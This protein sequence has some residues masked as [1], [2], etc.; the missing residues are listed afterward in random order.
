MPFLLFS[1][2]C[3]FTFQVMMALNKSVFK[4]DSGDG[5][6]GWIPAGALSIGLIS[7]AAQEILAT[8]YNYIADLMTFKENWKTEA[9]HTTALGLKLVSFQMLNYYVVLLFTAFYGE[10]GGPCV[11]DSEPNLLRIQ[12]Q[13][14]ERTGFT[15]PEPGCLGLLDDERGAIE[16]ERL[17]FKAFLAETAFQ[18]TPEQARNSVYKCLNGTTM[19]SLFITF[20]VLFGFRLLV[21]L[22][23]QY[24]VSPL[25]LKLSILFEDL[26]LRATVKN[27]ALARLS[28]AKVLMNKGN[29]ARL[30]NLQDSTPASAHAGIAK[31]LQ[32]LTSSEEQEKQRIKELTRQPGFLGFIQ[33]L[34]AFLEAR[35]TDSKENAGENAGASMEEMENQRP[36]ELSETRQAERSM[37]AA[38]RSSVWAV[39]HQ[40]STR[41]HAHERTRTRAHTPTHTKAYTNTRARTHTHTHRTI[42]FDMTECGRQVKLD[43]YSS[44][45]EFNSNVIQFGYLAFFSGTFPAAA[46]L[47]WLNNINEVRIDADK[48]VRYCRRPPLYHVKGVR[49]WVDALKVMAYTGMMV[50]I[51]ML[52]LSSFSLRKYLDHVQPLNTFSYFPHLHPRAKGSV[53]HVFANFSA[54][55]EDAALEEDWGSLDILTDRGLDFQGRIAMLW[56][57]ICMEHGLFL[58]KIFISLLISDMPDWVQEVIVCICVSSSLSLSQSHPP[59]H[60]PFLLHIHT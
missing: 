60:P 28:E 13:E 2:A 30:E 5:G 22:T 17:N 53:G 14:L 31:K 46:L 21:G 50:N 54:P 44:F 20:F 1:L 15:V 27:K 34:M 3:L 41:A 58:V 32:S 9:A 51:L 10:G 35:V 11:A 23:S 42:S 36:L 48:L 7:F 12:C 59:T 33:K 29:K 47:A 19:K 55:G 37:Q 56:F 52:G 25:Q 18:M 45:R 49:V 24:I 6:G 8:S 39:S 4:N 38:M 43:T 26:R 40:L 16:N 57:M